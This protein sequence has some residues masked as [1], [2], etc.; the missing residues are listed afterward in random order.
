M[1][2]TTRRRKYF[3]HHS[4]REHKRLCT[5]FLKTKNTLKWQTN[6]NTC[7]KRTRWLKKR[8]PGSEFFGVTVYIYKLTTTSQKYIRHRE[9]WFINELKVFLNAGHQSSLLRS[10]LYLQPIQRY[11]KSNTQ[12]STADVTR[13]HHGL[14]YR[15]FFNTKVFGIKSESRQ[16][17]CNE[18]AQC[19]F[20]EFHDFKYTDNLSWRVS[21]KWRHCKP[22]FTVKI[23]PTFECAHDL[24]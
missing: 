5:S 12:W 23:T 21:Q 17:Y 14:K 3:R 22:H 15:V 10:V 18:S 1:I 7:T 4:N 6:T 2:I 8:P 20:L 19:D 24:H 16:W 9:I 13:F 11:Q